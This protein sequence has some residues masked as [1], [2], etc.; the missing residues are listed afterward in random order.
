MVATDPDYR[1]RGLIRTQFEVLHAMSESMGHV[2]QGIT[3][4]PWYYRQFG[5][6]FALDLEGGRVVP[7]SAIPTSRKAKRT[8]PIAR[9]TIAD[10][11]F[12]S[13]MYD[14]ESAR[15]LVACPRPKGCGAIYSNHN[16]RRWRGVCRIKS[17]KPR[18]VEPWVMRRLARNVEM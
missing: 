14:H 5:Y 6:E 16:P 15:S 17:S 13:P 10:I 3:G 2:V 18:M 4:I 11:P 1:R 12:V 7:F 8:V 9:T